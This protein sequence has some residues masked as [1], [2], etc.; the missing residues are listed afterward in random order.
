MLEKMTEFLRFRPFCAP[1]TI[2]SLPLTCCNFFSSFPG[3][4]FF[5]THVR[6]AFLWARWAI[7]PLY[8]ATVSYC[9][10][11]LCHSRP[12]SLLCCLHYK[13]WNI[14]SWTIIMR[15]L[16]LLHWRKPRTRADY[17]SILVGKEAASKDISVPFLSSVL[18]SSRPA[19]LWTNYP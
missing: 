18:Q 14:W 17:R 9:L 13:A 7:W 6:T 19:P 2:S 4:H 8:G 16:W 15:T 11:F 10:V 12:V 1:N 5:K 3:T